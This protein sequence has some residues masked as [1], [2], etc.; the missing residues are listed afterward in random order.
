[1][2]KAVP[3]CFIHKNVLYNNVMSFET[4]SPRRIVDAMRLPAVALLAAVAASCGIADREAN[5]KVA[6][7][8]RTTSV[9]LDL[10]AW[11]QY[12]DRSYIPDSAEV[13]GISVRTE[14]EC[15]TVSDP[16]GLGDSPSCWLSLCSS[17]EGTRCVE[18]TSTFYDYEVKETEEVGSCSVDTIEANEWREEQ[19]RAYAAVC[20]A[21]LESRARRGDG[22]FIR[23]IKTNKEHFY[24]TFRLPEDSDGK[25]LRIP[26][27]V[28]E[29]T[30]RTMHIGD[31][32]KINVDDRTISG[33]CE[34]PAGTS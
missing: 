28:D 25:V 19:P 2:D 9:E 6:G 27:E 29:N 15:T 18:E 17:S 14:E 20:L 26:V 3:L 22:E 24:V 7:F 8:D 10:E 12:R 13:R 11:Y 16:W 21:G 30:W 32:A 33:P 31:C 5:G 34:Q 1:M 23:T 4:S